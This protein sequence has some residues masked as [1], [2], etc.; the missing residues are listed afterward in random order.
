MAKGYLIGPRM[1][2][3]LGEFFRSDSGS[4]LDSASAP[5][6]VE[7]RAWPHPFE[8]RWSAAENSGTGSWIV[9]LPDGCWGSYMPYISASGLVV[10][11]ENPANWYRFPSSITPAASA[12]TSIYA[13]INSAG[14][15]SIAASRFS[16]DCVLIAKIRRDLGGMD[17]EQI[18]SSPIVSSA[19]IKRAF[20][21]ENNTIVRCGL[22][23]GDTVVTCDD[24][25]ISAT[26]DYYAFV[27]ISSGGTAT[28]AVG[29]SQASYDYRLPLYTIYGSSGSYYIDDD[30]R[31][32]P[33]VPTYC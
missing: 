11:T 25:T 18:V 1:A 29:T 23:V 16:S 15:I 21:V 19:E 33:I 5:A 7:E 4:S 28:L 9:Y 8:I 26:G 2:R 30:Y 6:S 24:V 12:S 14:Y 17:V 3:R 32:Y 10:A 22:V 31:L 13:Y 27:T 20:D